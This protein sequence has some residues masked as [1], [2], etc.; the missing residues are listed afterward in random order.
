MRCPD[1]DTDAGE[2]IK[3][4][5]MEVIRRTIDPRNTA[6]LAS[7]DRSAVEAL[8]PDIEK[9]GRKRSDF[10]LGNGSG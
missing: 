2:I 5:R 3:L 1:L 4:R 7:S 6:E 10:F 8:Q 9:N